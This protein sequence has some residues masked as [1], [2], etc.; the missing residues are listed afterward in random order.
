MHTSFKQF[1]VEEEKTVYFTFGRM[2]PPTIGHGKVLEAL[3][4]KSAKNPYKVFLSQTK[5]SKKNP[6]T[7]QDKIKAVRKMFPRHAR[8]IM[9][10]KKVKNAM[11]AASSLYDEGYKNLVM[12]VGSDRINEFS[13]L[14][15]KY[16][17]KDGRH[18][19][20]NFKNINVISAG[21]R[22]PDAEGATG[23]SATK[24]REFARENNFTSFSQGLPKNVSNPDAKKM[25]NDV[26]KGMG[27]KEEN[28]F[29][30][31][32]QLETVSETREAFVRGE[33]FEVGQ[34]VIIEKTGEV[35][36][37]EIIGSNYV[38]VDINGNRSRQWPEAIE[39]VEEMKYD[40][41][42]PESV[43]LMKK[44][45]PGQNESDE[46]KKGSPQDPDIKDRKG[47]QPKA[48][49]A[50]LSKAQKISRD[51]QFKRQSK[52]DDDNPAAYKPAAGDKTAKTKPSKHTKRFKD[53][54][55]E[56]IPSHEKMAK[57]RIKKIKTNNAK[58]FDRMMDRA[59][60]RDT[61]KKNRE[62]K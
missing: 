18:G 54:F 44:M 32:V 5:D 52:M 3:A 39:I 53:M 55:G 58:R 38:I 28:E 24:M 17:G 61:N 19:F 57:E 47:T 33:L 56:D 10:D 22:D 37:I 31:H 46:R 25:F 62:T 49:H 4:K 41:G 23:M 29:K 45:T 26:R 1:L 9:L 40:Y 48:Y 14:L 59:R 20:Y 11:E 2:N 35:G 43:K 7:Y 16:N 13:T 15:K 50:G 21:D 36:K 8:S 34:D 42:S 51:R 27:L 60:N 30:R 12:V 6:L